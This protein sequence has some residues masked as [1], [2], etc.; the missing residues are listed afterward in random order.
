M[1]TSFSC[2]NLAKAIAS[3]MSLQPQE[4]HSTKETEEYKVH[5]LFLKTMVAS[6][7][8]VTNREKKKALKLK[9]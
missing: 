3:W 2:S 1:S 5:Y 8:G 4:L 6:L 7:K 9:N